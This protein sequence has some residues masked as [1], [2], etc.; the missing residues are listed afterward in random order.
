MFQLYLRN[1]KCCNRVSR[2]IGSITPAA[3]QLHF[4]FSICTMEWALSKRVH[5]GSFEVHHFVG[6]AEMHIYCPFLS[7]MFKEYI[8]VYKILVYIGIILIYVIYLLCVCVHML[9]TRFSFRGSDG[10][11]VLKT[12]VSGL[13]NYKCIHF[14]EIY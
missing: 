1:S 14:F 9:H 4:G 8:Q 12:E 6:S 13:R 7:I 2:V 10:K 11:W 5:V 3:L